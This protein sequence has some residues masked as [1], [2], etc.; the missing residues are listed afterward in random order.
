MKKARRDY[1]M[2]ARY[3]GE[4]FAVVLVETTGQ[5]AQVV[6]EKL[7]E[8]V[9]RHSFIDNNKEYKVTL[10]FGVADIKT[11]VDNFTKYDLISHADK[12]LFESKHAGGNKVTL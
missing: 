5:E 2:I 12:A 8:S 1:D 11:A 6:A 4:E 10:S 3:G 9:A 7:R